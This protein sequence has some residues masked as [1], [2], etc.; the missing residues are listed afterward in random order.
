MCNNNNIITIVLA[1][2]ILNNLWCNKFTL[3]QCHAL[4]NQ[5]SANLNV[6]HTCMLLSITRKG[7]PC[8]CKNVQF[9]GRERYELLE[10]CSWKYELN[11]T[12][13]EY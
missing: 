1:T 6:V 5:F 12:H 13:E 7:N 8:K 2:S 3:V 10:G 11:S 4:F 9:Q